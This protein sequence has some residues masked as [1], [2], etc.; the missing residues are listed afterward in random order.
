MRYAHVDGAVALA[1]RLATGI[2]DAAAAFG[3]RLPEL[4]C[5]FS[6]DEFSPPVPYPTSCS[7]QAWA[8]AAP[9]LLVRSFLGLQPHVP[10]RTVSL[11]PALPAAWGEVRLDELRLGPVSVNIRAEGAKVDVLGLPD[12]W[13]C[14]SSAD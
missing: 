14:L 3:A 12:D 2:L 11:S 10:S 1:H 7:P 6:R 9:V 13:R 5:G 8:S 4:F